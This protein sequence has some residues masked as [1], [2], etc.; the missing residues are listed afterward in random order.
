MSYISLAPVA[1]TGFRLYVS[2]YMP[3]NGC[4]NQTGYSN[5]AA[6]A[7]YYQAQET[8]EVAEQNRL[9]Q[10]F[11]TTMMKDAPVLVTVHDLNLRVLSP[12]VRGFVQPQSWFA[13]LKS[14]WVE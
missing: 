1:P 8:F 6:D 2:D 7:L 3:P 12:K 14:V 9:L 11:Q 5:A 4:C 13:D 10:Q